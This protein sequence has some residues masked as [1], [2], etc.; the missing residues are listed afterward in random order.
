MGG[1]F[2]PKLV[3]N[4][5][6]NWV[7]NLTVFSIHTS[8]TP[9][10]ATLITDTNVGPG[11]YY[12]VFHDLN[13][14]CYSPASA[15]ITVGIICADDDSYTNV[16]GITGGT[17]GNILSNDNFNSLTDG[18][19]TV[20]NVNITVLAPATPAYT[21]APIPSINTTTGDVTVPPGTPAGNYTITY[22]I[23]SKTTSLCDD[24]TVTVTVASTTILADDDNFSATPVTS[25]QATNLPTSVF[26]NDNYNG[27]AEGSVN[28]TNATL[29]TVGTWPTGITI[30]PS[31]GIV[32]VAANTAPGLHKVTYNICD[33]LNPGV[34]DPAEITIL[35][36]EYIDAVDNTYN[37]TAAQAIT[38]VPNAGNILTNDS[39]NNGGNGS[40]TTSTVN[41][42]VVTP[43]SPAYTGAPVPTLDITTGNVSVPAGT[44]AGNYTITYRICEKTDNTPCDNATITV[45]VATTTII[46]DN[47]DFSSTIIKA[48]QAVTIP[49]SV[50]ANDNYNGGAE[51]SATSANATLTVVGTWPTGITID[52]ITGI[53][54]VAANTAPGTHKVTYSICDKLNPGVCDTAEI[55]LVVE[56]GY[57]Y[58]LPT[59]TA[60]VTVPT[61]HG[62]TAL[63]RAGNATNEW[64]VARQSAWTVLEAKTKGFV[65][66]R[67]AFAA[68][69]NP[70][71][72]ATANFVEGMMVYDTTNN[73]LK[74]YN[75]T[76]WNCYSIPACP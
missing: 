59:K 51:G 16:N 39:V 24:A 44:P 36:A 45:N 72:I 49:T 7:V 30:N 75:G 22:R 9:S 1:Q 23:C 14:G 62:I 74:I 57:C 11:V 76:V 25:G 37:V 15:P 50:F 31:T 54:S 68:D 56:L 67:V 20:A 70:V 32:S 10:A 12:A 29:T 34:C 6:R 13:L 55:T 5:H 35:V 38:G 4:L 60:G 3:V 53:V 61:K 52:P 48:G 66:N 2:E 40:A 33:K 47:D 28:S 65:I 43:A 21:G 18:S 73:C 63:S 69:G 8:S 19:A 46:A 27:G 42:S 64:P 26:A 58:K 17:P 71:G 41:V